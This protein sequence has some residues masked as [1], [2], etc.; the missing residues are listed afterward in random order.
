MWAR[1]ITE[2]YNFERFSASNSVPYGSLEL[3]W[4]AISIHRVTNRSMLSLVTVGP[5][6][7]EYEARYAH[8]ARNRPVTGTEPFGAQPAWAHRHS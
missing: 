3:P 7:Q 4:Q 6:I 2:A 5:S 1:Q 8:C